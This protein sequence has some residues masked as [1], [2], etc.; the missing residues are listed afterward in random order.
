MPVVTAAPAVPAPLA[1]HGHDQIRI[2]GIRI[3]AVIGFSQ[4]EQDILQP[5]DV[6][7][8]IEVEP[9][10][11]YADDPASVLDYR[12][13]KDH[14][15][16]DLLGRRFRLLEA[17][18][19]TVARAVLERPGVQRVTVTAHKPGALTGARDVAFRLTRSHA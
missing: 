3:E 11:S 9:P 16:T 2:H 10:A 18:T 17:F 19:E 7:L 5:L 4:H 12:E 13:L 14:L 15:R 1:A 6:D 8:V